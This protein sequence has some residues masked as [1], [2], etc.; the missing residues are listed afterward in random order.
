ME[1]NR[2]EYKREL[3]PNLE[4]EVIAFLNYHLGGIIYIGID[5]DAKV[6]GVKNPDVLQLKIK[7][8]LKNNIL[9]SCMGLF[10][11]VVEEKENKPIVKIIVASG[12]EKPYYIAQKGMSEKGCYIRVGSAT[13][14]MPVRM[15]EDLF[16]KRT[17]NS[18]GKILSPRQ[19][20]T[21]AQLKIYYEAQGYNLN[22]NFIK[23]LELLTADGRFNY[24]AYLMSDK[25][26]ISIKLAKYSS[27]DRVDLIEHNEYGYCSLIKATHAII[28]KLEIENKTYATITSKQRIEQRLWDS[29]AIREAV[30]NAIVHNDYTREIPPKFE[31]FP[32]R[33]EITSYGGLFE[34]MDTEDFFSGLSLPVNKELMRIFRDLEMVEQLG[35]GIPRILKKYP[36]DS[37]V[38]GNSFTR[39]IFK[40][41]K[42][43]NKTEKIPL[44]TTQKTT[45]KILEL[46]KKNKYISR[47]EL[48]IMIENISEDGIKYHLTKMKKKGILKRIGPNKGGYWEITE[49][50]N[51]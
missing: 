39:I 30:I 21:F 27:L 4:K 16:A 42:I 19:N 22:N 37:F 3:T 15:I 7:D 38:F 40:F 8:R 14:P 2:I 36:K 20:L 33:L 51:E 24:V 31:I 34:G 50:N 49:L 45:Q 35:S 1:T 17:R 13:E 41:N 48:A 23:N 26:N 25:N 43:T 5:D 47:K 28:D 9:P 6:V 10:D 18:I 29:I 12:Y 46:I 44:E 32:D 11:V